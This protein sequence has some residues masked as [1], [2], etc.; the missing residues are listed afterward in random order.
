MLD[1]LD[2][3]IVM[4]GIAALLGVGFVAGR[5]ERDTRDFFLGG[6]AIPAWAVCLSFIATEISAATIVAVPAQAFRGDWGYLQLFIGSAAARLTVALLF[7]P[8]FFNANCTSIYEYLRE[9]FGPATQYTASTLFFVIRLLGSGLRLYIA[10]MGTALI[11]GWYRTGGD[12]GGIVLAIGLF[13]VVGIA[14]IS[15]GGIKAVIW[16]NVLQA[17]VFIAGGAATLM[18]LAQRIDGGFGG[19]MDVAGA[20]GK[21]RVLN[22]SLDVNDAGI[23]PLAVATGFLSSLAVFGTDQDFIQRLLTV[24]SRR[25]SQRSLLVTIVVALPAL[26]LFL[27]VGTLLWVFY[28]QNAGLPQPDASR[29][30]EILPQFAAT[31]MP[32]G[33]RG[34]LLLTIL[35]ASIDSPL[36]SLSA[37]FVTDI[38][39]PLIRRGADER[40]YLRVSR[41]AVAGFGVLLGGAAF[42]ASFLD[43]LLDVAFQI[44]GMLSGPMLGA[45][46]LGLLTK[47]R[48]D[49]G[50]SAAMIVGAGIT[51]ALALLIHLEVIGLAWTWLIL[52]G[53]MATLVMGWAGTR[54]A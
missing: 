32:H 16:T 43:K 25:A 22:L 3:L 21:L 53:T 49:S 34:L 44:L 11:L 48:G 10:A 23:L 14:F 52:I 24:E 18:Y 28:S 33:L 9:R 51:T 6:R 54:R 29:R 5:G 35:M 13:S 30:D 47:R 15:F 27:S 37:S 38:Y 42:A 17:F 39:R 2:A 19:A 4:A 7:L 1:S 26:L 31:V 50:V 40:H 8:A 45:F 41:M 46:L 36:G 12:K 20:A